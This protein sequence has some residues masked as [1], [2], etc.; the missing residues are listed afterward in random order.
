MLR[1]FSRTGD[2][3]IPAR[4]RPRL[5][6]CR[7]ASL[8][9]LV[10]A[11]ALAC[12]ASDAGPLFI[13][14]Q[15]WVSPARTGQSTQAYMNLTSTDGATLVGARSGDARRV[16]VH[17]PRGAAVALALPAGSEV[18]LKPGRDRIAL[19]GLTRTLKIGDRVTIILTVRD[20]DGAVRDVDVN[21]EVRNRSPVDDE[22]RA[23]HHH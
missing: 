8:Q 15:P 10:A 16:S 6:S 21:A 23:H 4:L 17:S 9:A 20:N 7:S 19:S 3:M 2:V 12:V 22:R 11:L 18:R 1:M 5:S 13:V 14:N